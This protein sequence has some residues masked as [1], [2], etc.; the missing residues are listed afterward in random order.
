MKQIIINIAQK[1]KFM[2]WIAMY[3]PFAAFTFIT[4]FGMSHD[5]C[6]AIQIPL[7]AF[8]VFSMCM[9]IVWMT[10]EFKE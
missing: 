4:D 8:Q 9:C 10:R 2:W 5:Q 1:Y 3:I 6:L 7:L